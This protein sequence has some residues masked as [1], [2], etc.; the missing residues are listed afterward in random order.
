MD[1]KDVKPNVIDT[2]KLIESSLPIDDK[3]YDELNASCF[4]QCFSALSNNFKKRKVTFK[5]S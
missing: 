2:K 4:R 3:I 1:Q 5:K